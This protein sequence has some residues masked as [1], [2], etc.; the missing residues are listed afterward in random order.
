MQRIDVAAV[1]LAQLFHFVGGRFGLAL[2]DRRVRVIDDH[3]GIAAFHVERAAEFAKRVVEAFDGLICV[4][5]GNA[6]PDEC[7]FQLDGLLIFGDRG[8]RIGNH[9][10]VQ[11]V[12]FPRLRRRRARVSTR[13]VV[14]R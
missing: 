8:L 1:A 11:I 6:R 2:G 4:T 14:P 9:T 13:A 10:A 5:E 3:G 12:R 7:G